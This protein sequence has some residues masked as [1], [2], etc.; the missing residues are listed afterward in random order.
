MQ[1][2]DEA[3]RAHQLITWPGLGA[4]AA[5]ACHRAFGSF[6]AAFTEPLVP[7]R[8]PWREALRGCREAFP[9]ATGMP[10]PLALPDGFLLALS[11]PLYPALLREI[12]SPPPLLYGQGDPLTLAL[13]TIAIVG[14]RHASQS[15]IDTAARFAT[16]LTGGGFVVASGLALGI[17]G[18]AHRGA[19]T[20]GLTLAVVGCG[21]DRCYPPSHQGLW[22]R[23][24]AAGG[25]VVSEFPPGTP[26][27]AAHFPR[28]NRIISGLSLGV[29]VV[30]AAPR[31]GSLITAR[32]ALE[33]G[34]EVF[35]IPGSIHNPLARGCH[36]LIR[37]GA[38]LVET[39]A[40]ILAQ[41]DGMLALKHAEAHAAAQ[42]MP[43]PN[44]SGRPR[45][46]GDAASV[47]DAL[48]HEP[49][50]AD[51]LM[52][53][54]GLD[55]VAVTSGLAELELAGLVENRGGAYQRTC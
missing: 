26:P 41:L 2:S 11:D 4:A 38:T 37:S 45:L 13:P 22:Q 10:A 34:R 32:L 19:L 39:T 8:E 25:A 31:S 20:G 12:P 5:L 7:L 52:A 44:A 46:E 53:R 30:E 35:A 17:D 29:L 18:A 1:P 24:V 28:R 36:Q 47:F 3:L 40:D 50:D 33:Q 21:I 9:A 27:R 54:T 51:L 48:G 14:S 23:I 49:A 55:V 43:G 6:A 42:P 15:G 16:E